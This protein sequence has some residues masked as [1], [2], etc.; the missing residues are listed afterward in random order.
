[1][2]I[3]TASCERRFAVAEQ[4]ATHGDA[5]N[6]LRFLIA[7][8]HDMFRQL[9]RQ[10]VESHPGWSVLAEARD[11]QE[12]VQ[13]ARIFS[14]DVALM[15]VVMPAHNGIEA[16]RMIKQSDPSICVILFSA[17]HEEEF[18]ASGLAAGADYF[19]WKEQLDD[20]SLEHMIVSRFSPG[21]DVGHRSS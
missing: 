21:G 5:L 11:G 20:A 18:R 17:H 1:M 13:L 16:T 14:P 19:V 15:D 2:V 8:D 9:I 4:R 3:H 10:M 7:D 6:I 12:A